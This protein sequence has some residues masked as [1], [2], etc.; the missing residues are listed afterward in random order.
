[1]QKYCKVLQQSI[2]TSKQQENVQIT[3]NIVTMKPI[4]HKKFQT[5]NENKLI[6]ILD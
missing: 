5:T 6:P 1:M 4:Q 3:E 2:V